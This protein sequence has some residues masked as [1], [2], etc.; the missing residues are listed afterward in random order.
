[1]NINDTERLDFMLCESRKVVV[2]IEGWGSAGRHYAVY[3]EEGFMSDHQAPAVRFTQEEDFN[4]AD[5]GGLH[6][7]RQAIDLAIIE[8]K[9]QSSEKSN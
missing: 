4:V 9:E 8:S 3:V 7:K 2:E 6:I 5:A 1:M